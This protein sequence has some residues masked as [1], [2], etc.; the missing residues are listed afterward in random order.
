MYISCYNLGDTINKSLRNDF[1]KRFYN[2]SITLY[3]Q[4]DI[5]TDKVKKG[6]GI[7]ITTLFNNNNSNNKPTDKK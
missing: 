1:F 3:K 7:I 2:N 4:I 6:C 5:V